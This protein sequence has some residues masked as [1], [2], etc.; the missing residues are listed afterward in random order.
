MSNYTREYIQQH[1][2]E[3]KRLLG[4]DFDQL[5]SLSLVDQK[6]LYI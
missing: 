2:Q 5:S 1:P 3:V 4:I 6:S